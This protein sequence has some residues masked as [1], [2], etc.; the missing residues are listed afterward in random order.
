MVRRGRKLR[1]SSVALALLWLAGAHA[2]HA[3]GGY[4]SGNQGSR[5]AGRAGAFAAKADDLSAVIYNPAGIAHL[6]KTLIQVSNRFSYNASEFTRRPT[7][8][9]GDLDNGVPPYVEFAT[10]R[11]QEPWQALDPLL[12][13]A[14]SLGQKDWMFALVAYAPAGTSR[15][16]FP[17][18]GGQRYLM[19]RREAIILDYSANVAWQY[20]QKVGLGLSLQWIHVPLLEYSLV[21]DANQFPGHANPV[22][23][24]LDMHARTKGSDPFT[25]NAVL[26]AW[27]RPAPYLEL[28]ISGQIIPSQIETDSTLTIDPIRPEIVDQVELLR[29][30]EPANDVHV[31]LPLPLTLRAGV[32]YR[33]LRGERE[34]FDVELD[35]SYESWSRV[36]RF[37]LDSNGI[38]ASLLAQTLDVGRIEVDKQWRDTVSLNLGGD[39]ALIPELFTLRGGLFYESAVASPAYANV[40]FA[41]GQ[42]L[43]GTVGASMALRAGLEVALAYE[44]R[45]QPSFDVSEGDARVYQEVPGS[46]CQAPYTDP[47]DCHPRYL[48]LPAPAVNAGRYAAYSHA[49]SL[50]VL[51]RF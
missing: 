9:W 3:A 13:V 1:P 11:N 48:G 22:S 8:D 20:G 26:G 15:V 19:V 43:G 24:E 32:R 25:F 12:G 38:R 33:E 37:S 5:A 7:L 50:D 41:G 29:G 44:Y 4:Y 46:Q 51:Y 36:K 23:S 42:Q 10:A 40:D 16:A 39:Y 31:T 2:A 47:N 18:D 28:G 30:G 14:S 49:A 34:L 6:D 21:I 27:Y 17:I 35:V 45:V